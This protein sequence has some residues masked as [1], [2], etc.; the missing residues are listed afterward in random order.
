MRI[1]KL[2]KVI[3][4]SAIAFAACAA[5]NAHAQS[6][7][8]AARGYGVC[9]GLD[10]SC[11]SGWVDRVSG[12]ESPWKV[13]IYYRVGEGVRPHANRE[14]GVAALTRE[15]E[16]RGYIVESSEDPAAMRAGFALRSYDAIVFFNTGRDALDSLGQMALRIYVGGGGGFVGIH[17]AFGTNF[18]W[19]WYEGL[20]GGAQLFDHAPLQ[21]ARVVVHSGR[22]VSTAHLP[23]ELVLTDEF[24]NL[25]PN[26][27][28]GGEVRL[29]LSVDESSM[30]RGT[31]GYYGHPGF[32]DGIHPVTWCHYYDGGRAWLTTLGHSEE[33]FENE[34]FL[35]H[36]VGGI[37][38]AMGKEPFCK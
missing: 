26:P 36:V 13:F 29:L 27:L 4:I 30:A 35:R 14:F 19:T 8:G 15:L 18:N 1:V 12:D 3:A 16:R 23:E 25:R 20:L 28:E 22:D 38:S 17:N 6:P 24:Y 5:A 31:A 9:S 10:E 37:E 2:P 21:P 34:D 11:Y 33:I 32:G 7:L